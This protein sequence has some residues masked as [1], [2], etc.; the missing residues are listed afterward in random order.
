MSPCFIPSRTLFSHCSTRRP[1]D[2]RQWGS[3]PLYRTRSGI[4][5]RGAENTS[6]RAGAGAHSGIEA[7]LPN[8]FC[9]PPLRGGYRTQ[10]L[11]LSPTESIQERDFAGAPLRTRRLSAKVPGQSSVIVLRFQRHSTCS[12]EVS[13]SNGMKIPQKREKYRSLR[14]GMYKLL[15]G[16]IQE[17]YP[18][19]GPPER[20]WYENTSNL[21]HHRRARPSWVKAR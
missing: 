10:N 7:P 17:G 14:D 3:V 16:T 2:F 8:V 4:S 15:T 6:S 18:D 11:S 9:R 1:D 21:A 20:Q 19:A 12:S 13:V 5:A